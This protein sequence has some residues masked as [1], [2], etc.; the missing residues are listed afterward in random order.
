MKLV[1]FKPELDENG[2]HVM[3]MPEG[4]KAVFFL[5]LTK[6]IFIGMPDDEPQYT[7]AELDDMP[8]LEVKEIAEGMGIEYTT[9]PKT[10]EAILEVQDG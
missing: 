6:E 9:K 2:R 3:D 1:P 5:P 10:I 8:Y 7:K 4:A